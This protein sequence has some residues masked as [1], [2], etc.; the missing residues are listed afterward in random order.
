MAGR[1]ENTPSTASLISRLVQMLLISQ[2]DNDSPV[3]APANWAATCRSD[4]PFVEIT[5]EG[6]GN[7]KGGIQMSF[8]PKCVDA[9]TPVKTHSPTQGDDDPSA[10][11]SFGLMQNDV[12][13]D[14][15][16]QGEQQAVPINSPM[17]GDM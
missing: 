10:V 13:Y 8:S 14:P 4:H 3:M 7:G 1:T 16:S 6:H 12:G 9:N 11:V 5:K 17:N 2:P 15:A